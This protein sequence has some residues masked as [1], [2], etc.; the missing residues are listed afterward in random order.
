MS[1]IQGRYLDPAGNQTVI[2]VKVT[3]DGSLATSV[4]APPAGSVRET[5]ESTYQVNPGV[6][7][8]EFG[9]GDTLKRYVVRDL[10]TAPPTVVSTY[11]E[12]ITRLTSIGTPPTAAQITA[13]SGGAG[14]STIARILPTASPVSH[15]ILKS[16]AGA[17]IEVTVRSS[18]AGFLYLFDLATLPP[19]GTLTGA[20]LPIAPPIN[21]F[22]NMTQAISWADNP[23]KVANGFVAAFSTTDNMV[24]TISPTAYF[25]GRVS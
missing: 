3:A 15:E 12:N 8:A 10:S 6:S 21:V 17:V 7:S 2:P 11:W 25:S 19:N 23:Y 16:T 14:V 24:L 20:D 1:L 18:I 22:A 5:N 13:S 9:P 4:V